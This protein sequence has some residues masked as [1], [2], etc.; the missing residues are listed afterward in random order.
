LAINKSV[1]GSD[2]HQGQ[3]LKSQTRAHAQKLEQ[4]PEENRNL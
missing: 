4:V 2:E 3:Q 1:I